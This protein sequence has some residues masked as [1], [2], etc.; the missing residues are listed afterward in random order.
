MINDF[1]DPIGYYRT[2]N[3]RRTLKKNFLTKIEKL[4]FILQIENCYTSPS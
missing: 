2:F 1:H 4:Y 3:E